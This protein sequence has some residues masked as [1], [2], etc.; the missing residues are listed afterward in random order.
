MGHH[1][2]LHNQ[3]SPFSPVLHCLLGLGKLQACQFLTL[4]SYLFLCLPCLLSPFT[5]LC[6]ARWFWPDLMNRRHV[7]TT[8]VCVTLL[9][10]G[11]LCVVQLPAGSWHGN[12]SKQV[13]YPCIPLSEEGNRQKLHLTSTTS[14]SCTV[15]PA[16]SRAARDAGTGPMPMILGSQPAKQGK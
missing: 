4:S 7:H 15:L 5:V 6:L 10:S 3:F 11:G 14:I 1:R 12:P 16:F 9:W 8:A 2:W 13:T